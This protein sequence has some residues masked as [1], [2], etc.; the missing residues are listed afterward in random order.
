MNGFTIYFTG[1]QWKKIFNQK[2]TDEFKSLFQT[3]LVA[4]GEL[5]D[6]V[7]N[8]IFFENVR[9]AQVV[10]TIENGPAKIKAKAH[11][12]GQIE[13]IRLDMYF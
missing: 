13:A 6:T 3:N 10:A 5:E 9:Q 7:F 11:R 8:T 4:K 1:Q 12:Y 2:R